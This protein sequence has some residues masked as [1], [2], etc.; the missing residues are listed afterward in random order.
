MQTA[1]MMEIALKAGEIIL[2]SGAEI[3]RVEETIIRICSSYGTKCESFVL[4]T[5]I[6]I[7]IRDEDGS[8]QTAFKRIRQRT[9]DLNRIDRINTFSRGLKESRLSYAEA[10]EQLLT[11][12]AGRQHNLPVRLAAAVVAS[13]VFTMLFQGS[14]FDSMAAAVVGS[15]VYMLKEFLGKKGFFQFFELFSAGLVAGFLS[16]AAVRLFPGLNEYKIIIGSMMLYLPGMAMT[17]SIKDAFY[18]DLVASFTRMG[19]AFLVAAAVA[20]GVAISLSISLNWG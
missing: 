12:E 19:E 14:M 16:I 1:E 4:P 2:T 17:N 9:V 3:Y 10:A 13:F 5:G 20:A 18:G 7:T 8:M 6:F 15:L 11:I